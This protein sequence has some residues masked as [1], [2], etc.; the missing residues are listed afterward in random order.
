MS[1]ASSFGSLKNETRPQP[2]KKEVQPQVVEISSVIPEAKRPYF[3]GSRAFWNSLWVPSEDDTDA[4]ELADQPFLTRV[5]CPILD[6]FIAWGVLAAFFIPTGWGPSER[7]M[8][9]IEPGILQTLVVVTGYRAGKTL[10]GFRGALTGAF[11]SLGL[12]STLE[13]PAIFPT[14]VYATLSVMVLRL[15]D[16]CVDMTNVG[17]MLHPMLSETLM[18]TL[19]ITLNVLLVLFAHMTGVDIMNWLVTGFGNI[20]KELVDNSYTPLSAL[21]IEPAKILFA[22]NAVNEDT[23]IPLGMKEVAANGKTSA[24]MLETNFGPGLGILLALLIVGP[25]CLRA[26]LVLATIV[27]FLGGIHEVYFPYVYMNPL[28]ILPLILSGFFG[29]IVF[30]AASLGYTEPPSPGSIFSIGSVVAEGDGL[31]TAVGIGISVIVSF[32]VTVLLYRRM[33]CRKLLP[34]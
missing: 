19:F 18:K 7:Y 28:L 11:V 15:M 25:K 13:V 6:I 12:T 17:R 29:Q 20:T 30:E 8:T 31:M 9:M 16:M 32:L 23:L 27:Q 4:I 26:G 3:A 10:Y 21:S 2:K 33:D 5:F 1:K 34:F 22:N 24:F 14:L